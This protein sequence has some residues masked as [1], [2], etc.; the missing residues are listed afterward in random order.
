MGEWRTFLQD[1]PSRVLVE[2]GEHDPVLFA[3]VTIALSGLDGASGE[4]VDEWGDLRNVVLAP[5]VTGEIFVDPEADP[6]AVDVLRIV[7]LTLG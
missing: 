5:A 4:P 2:I 6:P 1:Q 7:W 3:R